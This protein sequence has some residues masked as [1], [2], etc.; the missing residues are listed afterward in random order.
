MEENKDKSTEHVSISAEEKWRVKDYI[1]VAIVFGVI[2]LIAYV[3]TAHYELREKAQE[4]WRI[5]NEK[6]KEEGKSCEILRVTSVTKSYEP[7]KVELSIQY[8]GSKDTQK[9]SLPL[10]VDIPVFD[11]NSFENSTYVPI[12]DDLIGGKPS[13]HAT[14]V[15]VCFDDLGYVKTIENYKMEEDK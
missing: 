15:K 12:L 10:D 5:A 3:L 2:A 14:F 8:Y 7:R 6:L 11:K 4:D 1:I 13:N 9:L